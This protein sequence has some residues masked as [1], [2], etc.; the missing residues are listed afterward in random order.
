M[1]C[2]APGTGNQLGPRLGVATRALA[3]APTRD[4]P[5]KR[6][7]PTAGDVRSG[8]GTLPRCPGAA[9]G[10]ARRAIEHIAAPSL[11]RRE[12]AG[13]RTRCGLITV[14]GLKVPRPGAPVRCA[15][16]PEAWGVSPRGAN[17][18]EPL[19]AQLRA[20]ARMAVE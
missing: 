18:F 15:V 10:K 5:L 17:G 6:V 4:T 11:P 14:R 3:V 20:R 1:Q 19:R 13:L 12:R 9:A 16:D 2:Y 8:R 7:R